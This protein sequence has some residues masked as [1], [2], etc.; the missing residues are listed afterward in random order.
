[1]NKPSFNVS[2]DGRTVEVDGTVYSLNSQGPGTFLQLRQ[3]DY[4]QGFEQATFRQLL[5]LLNSAYLNQENGHAN[6]LVRTSSRK[7]V[8][9]NTLIYTTLE[10]VFAIDNPQFNGDKLVATAKD[11]ESRLGKKQV[12]SVTFSYDGL[13]RAMP[14]LECESGR[15]NQFE[16]LALNFLTLITGDRDAPEKLAQIL[17]MFKN[18]FFLSAPLLQGITIPGLDGF[19]DRLDLVSYDWNELVGKDKN[20]FGVRKS[21]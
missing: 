1:M 15:Y 5:N 19:G 14:R 20:S 2:Q 10:N 16:V 18:P 7:L 6:E 13:V 9:G 21:A 4:G 17:D 12:R 8:M 11:L 3:A